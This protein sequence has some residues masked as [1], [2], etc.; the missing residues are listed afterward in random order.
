MEFSFCRSEK[1]ERPHVGR[2]IF[3]E[4][5]VKGTVQLSESRYDQERATD[6]APSA[7]RDK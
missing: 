2:P 4:K 6:T 3:G 7:E 5:D 1:R